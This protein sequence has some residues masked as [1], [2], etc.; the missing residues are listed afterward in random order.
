[1]G[2]GN[3]SGI[4]LGNDVAPETGRGAIGLDSQGDKSFQ[5][6]KS[7]INESQ[8]DGRR[9]SKVQKVFAN[10]EENYDSLNIQNR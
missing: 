1:M 8:L 10:N 2:K 7:E 6:L 3:G 9:P 5:P 4:I